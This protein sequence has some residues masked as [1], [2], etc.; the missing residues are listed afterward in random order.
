MGLDA[1]AAED[2][3]QEVFLV[4]HRRMDS[5]ED[6][7]RARAWLFGIARRVAS[8]IRQKNRRRQARE[9]AYA[10]PAAAPP[11]PERAQQQREARDLVERFLT[12]LDEPRRTAF[13][14][15]ELEEFTG[16]E[17]AEATGWKL[18]TVFTRLRSARKKFEAFI[19]S[20]TTSRGRP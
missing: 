11:D 15:F 9:D 19:E 17:I 8:D 2:A 4:A 20:H 10:V 18:N 6:I 14:L 5:L 3:T 7:G 12:T 16:R 13:V 1:A